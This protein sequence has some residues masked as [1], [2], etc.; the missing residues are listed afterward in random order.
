VW[1]GILRFEDG[2]PRWVLN[3]EQVPVPRW[4]AAKGK[5][6]ERPTKFEDD[7]K[8]PVGYRLEP[9]TFGRK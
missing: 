5:V 6:R 3:K 8:Q 4:E 2:Q 1:A 7:K 9:L